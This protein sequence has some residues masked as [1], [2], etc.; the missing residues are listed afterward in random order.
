[1]ALKVKPL[2][3]I[4]SKWASRSQNAAQAYTDGV[5]NPKRDWAATTAA[6][7]TNWTAGVTNA[8]TNKRF[9]A[10]V[11]RVGNDGWSTGAVNKGASRY[12]PGV[13]AGAPKFTANF[14]RFQTVLSNLTLPPRFP[15]GDPQ[16]YAR[17]QAIG[18]A[19]RQA[20]VGK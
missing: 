18:T 9:S 12:G 15:K 8:A 1:M 7:E 10:G 14:G 19:L 4:A 11:T 3:Q 17:V 6:A 5:K 16:N 2:D 20:K 13:A